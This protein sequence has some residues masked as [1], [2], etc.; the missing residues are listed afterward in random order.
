MSRVKIITLR[1][2]FRESDCV[3]VYGMA[4]HM[5]QS[6]EPY[7]LYKCLTSITPV[8]AWIYVNICLGLHQKETLSVI[9]CFPFV[10]DVYLCIY[11]T[12]LYAE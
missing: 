8:A 1:L 9:S 3:Y 10:C 11:A 2:F 7:R 4:W 5:F 12:I 6:N